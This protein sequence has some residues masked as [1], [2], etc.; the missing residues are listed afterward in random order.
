MKMMDNHR[1][2]EAQWTDLGPANEFPTNKQACVDIQ[3][4]RLV[5]MNVDDEYY[6][7]ENQCPHA[8]RPL[9]DGERRGMTITCPYH[10]YTYHIK[11]GKSIDYPEEETPVKTFPIRL[12]EGRV[13]A[14]LT[15]TRDTHE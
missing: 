15:T 5:V 1:M 13:E 9:G 6:A 12:H 3:G 7:I 14:Q 8:G 10:G 4:L 11:T 2:T